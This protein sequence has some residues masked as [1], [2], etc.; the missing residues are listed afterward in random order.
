[1]RIAVICN[2]DS[3]ALPVLS[4]LQNRGLLLGVSVLEK[5]AAPLTPLLNS[6][7]ITTDRIHLLKNESW[8]VALATWLQR[9]KPDMTWVF[10]FPWRIPASILSIPA[11]G[12]LNF[13]FG[14]LPRY[15]G[16]DPLFWQMRNR[17]SSSDLTVHEMTEKIDEG[18]VMMTYPMPM[19][20]GENYGLACSR[21]GSM[22]V[23]AVE[24]LL[25][26]YQGGGLVAQ[27]QPHGEALYYKKPDG[28]QLKIDWKAQRADEIETLVNAS[29]P[30]YGGATAFIRNMEVRILETAPAD[31][32]NAP[33]EEPGTIV[34]ADAVYGL[35]VACMERK[36]L[37]INVV[38][39]A[40]GYFSGT[41]LFSMGIK[42]GE[43][44]E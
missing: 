19:L 18:P 29:N 1:M 2:T 34:H 13:H 15:K 44:F 43:K 17:E 21:M 6:I 14:T 31:I 25:T 4:F 5:F 22:A 12:F 11:K 39:M 37:R 3:L 36:F 35:I 7:G 33:Q 42:K 40:E 9:L 20:P 27:Q 26:Q 41:K 32:P 24:Q 30:R 8:K 10:A 23:G 16:A 38:H 28:A